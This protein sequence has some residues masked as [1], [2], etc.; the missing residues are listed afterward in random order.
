MA[1]LPKNQYKTLYTNG[2]EYRLSNTGKI[3]K[4]DYFITSTGKVFAGEN[5]QSLIG[6]LI[7]L[8]KSLNNN[9][10]E[11]PVNN[12]KYAIL[13]PELSKKQNSYIPIP[14]SQTPPTIL[15]YSKGFFTR[16]FAVRLN[17]KSYFEISKETFQNFQFRNYNKDLYK[18]FSLPW[19]LG[20]N[21]RDEN[22][23][24]LRFYESKLPGITNFFPDKAQYRRNNPENPEISENLVAGENELFFLDGTPYPAGQLYHVHPEKGPMEG[25]QHVSQTHALLSFNSPF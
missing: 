5:P 17:T 19:S 3:Y 10:N 20:P 21:S 6:E 2:N 23:K 15:D 14:S 8:K 9:I 12:R 25:G 18:V 22:L 1:Y 7:P 13:Q 11:Y 24:T 4:G 16:F